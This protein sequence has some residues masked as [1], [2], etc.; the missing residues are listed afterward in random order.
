MKRHLFLPAFLLIAV[1]GTLLTLTVKQAFSDLENGRTVRR[2]TFESFLA[3]EYRQAPEVK[4]DKDGKAVDSPD[5]AAFQEYLMTL[6]PATG[7]V[8]RERLI[9]AYTETR[10][11]SAMKSSMTTLEWEGYGADMG[12]RTRAIMYDPNDPSGK[13]VWAGGV[14]GGLWYNTNIQSEFSSWVPVG[15]FWP[16]LSIRC[17]RITPKPFISAPANPK[18]P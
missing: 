17:I 12:G 5:M 6:D 7:K 18:R 3:S 2:K 9:N 10:Q 16:V 15:D 8:P 14:T 1:T 11:A 4:K 13:K